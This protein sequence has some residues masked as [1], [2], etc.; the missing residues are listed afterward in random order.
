MLFLLQGYSSKWVCLDFNLKITGRVSLHRKD[1]CVWY[2]WYQ[3]DCLLWRP[4]Q[5]SRKRNEQ[6]A[7][8]D[9]KLNIILVMSAF[10][11]FWHLPL[12]IK[13]TGMS[14]FGRGNLSS[15]T[16]HFFFSTFMYLEKHADYMQINCFLL[17]KE[18]KRSYQRKKGN[19]N[20]TFVYTCVFQNADALLCRVLNTSNLKWHEYVYTYMPSKLKTQRL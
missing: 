11:F 19:F 9:M 5:Q 2:W 18:K 12:L 20:I 7:V 1:Q 14:N 17:V 16:K 8:N 3:L 13:K 6:S 4:Q 15:K 10:Q